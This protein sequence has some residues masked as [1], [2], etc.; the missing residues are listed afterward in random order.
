MPSSHI[1]QEG[2]YTE[3]YLENL[4]IEMRWD[5][6]NFKTTANEPA[7]AQTTTTH[8]A[9]ECLHK[10]NLWPVSPIL[11]DMYVYESHKTYKLHF[12]CDHAISTHY[13]LMLLVRRG[14]SILKISMTML[15]KLCWMYI[16]TMFYHLFAQIKFDS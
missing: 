3:N 11:L 12:V 4:I 6:V 7:G 2:M 14:R 5:P 13:C 16:C 1:A 15:H 9:L 10:S 8:Y